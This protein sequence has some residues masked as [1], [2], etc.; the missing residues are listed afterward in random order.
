[1]NNSDVIKQIDYAMEEW[2]KMK[3][4]SK[5]KDLSDLG[6]NSIAEIVTKLLTTIDRL[7]PIGSQYR[8]MANDL[9]R[10]YSPASLHVVHPR[11]YGIL[12]ALKE[13]Y[14]QGYLQS[15]EELVHANVFSDF[16]EMAEYLLKEGYKDPAAVLVGGVLEEHLRKLC[17]KNSIPIQDSNGKMRKASIMNDDLAKS[18]YNKLEQKNVM[19]WL[20]LRN[21]A[22]HG[23]Y[24]KYDLGQVNLMLQG[25]QQFMMRQKA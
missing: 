24:D 5:N 4:R 6:P 9:M 3:Q 20:D 17:V 15:I 19:T 21:K 12:K 16:L 7:S 25:V 18:V 8:E 13:A 23:E 10:K 22:A 2:D 1:M 14:E 11:L